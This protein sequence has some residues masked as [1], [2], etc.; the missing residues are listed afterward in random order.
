MP[1][2]SNIFRTTL[3]A[4]LILGLLSTLVPQ[5]SHASNLP[6]FVNSVRAQSSQPNY[7]TPI[8]RPDRSKDIST[9]IYQAPI[10]D[11][12][13]AGPAMIDLKGLSPAD[14]RQ[15]SHMPTTVAEAR[16][17]L[18]CRKVKLVQHLLN[19]MVD[20]RKALAEPDNLPI[21]D[22][23][24]ATASE[25]AL[26][27]A[28]V[29]AC[30]TD[31]VV[32][33]NVDCQAVRKSQ[34]DALPAIRQQ[35]FFGEF[36]DASG[37]WDQVCDKEKA[38]FHDF[39]KDLRSAFAHMTALLIAA[40]MPTD[41]IDE[42]AFG[43]A[44]IW[45]LPVAYRDIDM[46]TLRGQTMRDDVNAWIAASGLSVFADAGTH[47]AYD[48][49]CMPGDYDFILAELVHFLHIFR[50]RADLLL[51][52]SVERLLYKN[53][54][55]SGPLVSPLTPALWAQSAVPFTG[56][57]FERELWY[58]QSIPLGV[59]H[60][61][62]SL[63]E[64]ENHVLMTLAHYY[65][66]NQWLSSGRRGT[67]ADLAE[68]A[69]P[70]VDP[71]AWFA[72]EGSALQE[73]LRDV[74]GRVLHNGFFETNA[75]PYHGYSIRALAAL[76]AYAQDDLIR[77]EAIN[78][79][80]FDAT[81]FT[82]QS[83]E[84][85]RF[86]PMRRNCEYVDEL[87]LYNR[88]AAGVAWGWLS[89]AYKWNDSPYGFRLSRQQPAACFGASEG[90]GGVAEPVTDCPWR[91]YSWKHD[92]AVDG[93]P[94]SDAPVIENGAVINVTVQ[95][96]LAENI[97]ATPT[98]LEDDL[99]GPEMATALYLLFSNYELPGAIHE[100][101]L[102]KRDGYFARMTAQYETDHYPISPSLGGSINTPGYFNGDQ[103]FD[104]V[105]D[106]ERV[107]EFYFTAPGFVNVA[108]GI[109]NPL[110]DRLVNEGF[111][112][113]EDKR[114][115][116]PSNPFPPVISTCNSGNKAVEQ[117]DFL[118]KPYGVL[119]SVPTIADQADFDNDNDVNELSYY[120]PFGLWQQP[121][122]EYNRR[123]L[124]KYMPLML[125]DSRR[126]YKSANI[127]SYK[128]FSY[129]YEVHRQDNVADDLEWFDVESGFWDKVLNLIPNALKLLD[130]YLAP[131]SKKDLDFPH[132]LPAAW[133]AETVPHVE[134]AI[135]AAAFRVFDLRTLMAE[136][137][138]AG[139]YLITARV[140]KKSAGHWSTKVS[141][142][143]WEVVPGEAF[144]SLATLEERIRTLN[145]EDHFSF[146]YR[147]TLLFGKNKHYKYRLAMSGET[148]RLNQYYGAIFEN[149]HHT[150]EG[151]VQG[152]NSIG[153]ENG[154]EIAL[155]EVHL[156]FMNNDFMNRLPLLDV[157]AVNRDFTFRRLVPEADAEDARGPYQ[158][159]ACAQDGWL[160]VNRPRDPT[161]VGDQG[162]WLFVDSRRGEPG[163]PATPPYFQGG[164]F[165]G[166]EAWRTGCGAGSG[167]AWN[168]APPENGAVDECN[169]PEECPPGGDNNGGGNGGGQCVPSNLPCQ[170]LFQCRPN[171][172]CLDLD[173]N[174]LS[175]CVCPPD[176]DP[177]PPPSIPPVLA[178]R[179][180][181]PDLV[182]EPTLPDG[183]AGQ[184]GTN[185]CLD[186]PQGGL[187][188]SIRVRVR[189]Q[190]TGTAAASQLSV[191]FEGTVLRAA[192][193]SLLSG[194]TTQHTFT[195][196]NRCYAE[197]SNCTFQIHVDSQLQVTEQNEGNNI[198][199]D[200]CYA[201]IG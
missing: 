29:V 59:A 32:P 198:V 25:Q 100:F 37:D 143:F 92:T 28:R 82:F 188:R 58:G 149:M 185:Y 54:F 110:Y 113:G 89:G 114:Y 93:V 112:G 60:I 148:V 166:D 130:V 99:P 83:L 62:F 61:D 163:G 78:A 135:E 151:T 134:F 154:E 85:R 95:D 39:N 175:Q 35:L 104:S 65:L 133:T 76:A 192:I 105:G 199:S 103:P 189:N 2:R 7:N 147:D 66:I 191:D 138:Q 108:G 68:I 90:S 44:W 15:P 158:F 87:G 23:D 160:F 14:C 141:R 126:F 19:H 177:A 200:F 88:D 8:E 56:Q 122:P 17:E 11:F 31:G 176:P 22:G 152:I 165:E 119:T 145:P 174:G 167:G 129:G 109:Y 171:N 40:S 111:A 187:S 161:V 201:L 101:L 55:G 69:A 43:D 144:A 159:Y 18:P 75:R 127:A 169:K 146:R 50:D 94:G 5:A 41:R 193:P 178:G 45:E 107:P 183:P 136:Q 182:P 123:E 197:G 196:P 13:I 73:K 194:Q 132:H 71:Q 124:G 121:D 52:S 24:A 33:A 53:S 116:I 34:G 96:V 9:A 155:G 21:K 81:Q 180:G 38:P 3:F 84:G 42:A 170:T 1:F 77:N 97:P 48:E 106:N 173:N 70:G 184:S 150:H 72:S 98:E 186:N 64:T 86:M 172:V 6:T 157:K 118:S 117:Y 195:I 125:G 57:E 91:F 27:R 4:I 36:W 79:L 140:R 162:R 26:V 137:G 74:I 10:T 80:H 142:G 102:D 179:P 47:E 128:N 51:D 153:D 164:I 46:V 156:H 131:Y 16:A 30:L 181:Q 168:P 12:T 139:F 190:G 120:A 63:A 115:G 20:P 67:P 49:G